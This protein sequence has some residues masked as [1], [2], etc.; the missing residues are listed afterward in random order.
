MNNP[1]TILATLDSFLQAQTQLVLYGRA[2]LALG[3]GKAGAALAVTADVD[4]ILPGV[5]MSTIESDTQFWEALD[6]TNAALESRGLRSKI[7]QKETK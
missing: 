3:Y 2:A 5:Q 6:R 7:L 1:Q 4:V